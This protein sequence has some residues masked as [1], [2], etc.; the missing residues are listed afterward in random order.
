MKLDEGSRDGAEVEKITQ[1]QGE[2]Y[3][4]ITMEGNTVACMG[5]SGSSAIAAKSLFNY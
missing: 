4:I 2:M 3:C 1:R 5:K